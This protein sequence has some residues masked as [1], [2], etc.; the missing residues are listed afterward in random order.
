MENKL[1]RLTIH[2]ES[3]ENLDAREMGMTT[4]GFTYSL[5][6][7]SYCKNSKSFGA[8]TAEEC[9]AHPPHIIDQE[10]IDEL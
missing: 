3:I 7:G 2:K 6:L 10:V 4:G 1:S 9:S 8:G 5:S